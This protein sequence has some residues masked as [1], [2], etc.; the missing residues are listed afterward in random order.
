MRRNFSEFKSFVRFLGHGRSTF[1]PIFL[2][3]LPKLPALVCLCIGVFIVDSD[4]CISSCG[5]V[6]IEC[7]YNNCVL[8]KM[9]DLM[10]GVNLIHLL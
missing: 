2:F 1:R 8:G 5:N 3:D 6:S 10:L 9:V 4:I 7:Y